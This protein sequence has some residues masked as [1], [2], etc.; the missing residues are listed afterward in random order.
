MRVGLKRRVEELSESASRMAKAYLAESYDGVGQYVMV[1][2]TRNGITAALKGRIASGDFGGGRTFPEGTPVIV[3]SYRGHIEVFLGNQPAKC[4]CPPTSFFDCF[5]ETDLTYARG[6]LAGGTVGPIQLFPDAL[7]QVA[8]AQQITDGGISEGSF[9]GLIKPTFVGSSHAIGI[10]TPFS[11]D[12]DLDT[13]FE[14]HKI[15]RGRFK[16]DR[17]P[18]QQG[19]TVF[20]ELG[21]SGA[22]LEMVMGEGV[23]NGFIRIN[24]DHIKFKEDWEADTWYQFLWE[25]LP[26]NGFV[27]TG[28]SRVKV[29]KCSESEPEEWDVDEAPQAAGGGGRLSITLGRNFNFNT[30]GDTDVRAEMDWISAEDAA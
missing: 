4:K 29:W 22:S 14:S 25:L 21:F 17:F 27:A 11:V 10:I 8:V 24:T 15:Y 1:N 30:I 20:F 2:L 19:N 18:L 13:Y 9:F 28:I 5:D 7:W 6:D 23:G 26:D 12:P 3:S 16:I